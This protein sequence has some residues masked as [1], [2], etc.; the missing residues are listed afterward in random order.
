[1]LVGGRTGVDVGGGG[2]GGGAR[3]GESGKEGVVR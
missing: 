2:C 1:M 3:R